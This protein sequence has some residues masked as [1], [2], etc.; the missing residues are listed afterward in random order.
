M[1]LLLLLLQA[2]KE[3]LCEWACVPVQ[4]SPAVQ[5]SV[6]PPAP[7][8]LFTMH[9]MVECSAVRHRAVQAVQCRL[10]R[11]ACC[12]S[13]A[14]HVKRCAGYAGC[15]SCTHARSTHAA[16]A[17]R[18]GECGVHLHTAL[19]G[20]APPCA[21]QCTRAKARMRA[22][23]CAGA[24]GNAL[25]RISP[26]AGHRPSPSPPTPTPSPALCALRPLPIRACDKA[27]Q[28]G[29]LLAH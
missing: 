12:A 10:Q 26:P 22:T 3:K 17:A 9:A 5:C 15:V 6:P 11:C 27:R 28:R 7:E 23:T 8:P 18:A 29:V 2:R 16:V 25:P 14:V 20:H 13:Y 1:Q 21:L 24:G 4:C 19:R